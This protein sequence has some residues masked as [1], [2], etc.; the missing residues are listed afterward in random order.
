MTSR[1]RALAALLAV[2]LLGP[3]TSSASGFLYGENGARSL[4]LG[5]AFAGQADDLTAIQH[6]PAGL[7]QQQ[8]FSFLVDLFLL[9][10]EVTFQRKDADGT[11][12]A[13]PVSNSGG[14]FLLPFFAAGYG[15]PVANRRLTLSI[16]A[17][18]PP[19]VGRYAFPKPNYEKV[20]KNGRLTYV[21]D[22]RKFAPQRYGLIEND[23]IVLFPSLSA[24]YEV[25]P[26][27]SVGV[28]LQYVYSHID[29]QIAATSILFTPTKQLHEDADFDS[30]LV[31][32]QTGKPTATG[33]LGVLVKP[34]DF[35]R[36]GISYRPPVPIDAEGEANIVL[37]PIPK[38]FYSVEGNRATFEM[39]L[40]QELKIGA[41][42]TPIK[43]L[44]VNVDAVYQGWQSVG[45][46]L[47]T[48]LDIR[49]VS[50]DPAV[51][52]IHL[53]PIHIP[54]KWRHIWSFR[55]GAQYEF[56][57][58][59]T[60]RAGVLWEQSAAGDE[61]LAIDFMH[62]TRTFITG[63]L[64]YKIPRIGVS[65]LATGAYQPAVTKEVTGSEVRAPNTDHDI[66]GSIIGNGTLTGGGWIL[67][68]GIR[69]TFGGG[70][71]AASGTRAVSPNEGVLTL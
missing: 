36:I 17:Y 26:K 37:G 48:P 40:P 71:P 54:K 62:P 15:L 30:V 38:Q 50:P 8:G 24:A 53:E 42:L 27:L 41:H 67:G 13:G 20:E 29:F 70:G 65:V 43:G 21:E 23:I 28:S 45:E 18:G 32:D 3:A 52:P 9:N 22:P 33:V 44:G 10:H 51:E 5:G 68:G 16:G 64:E 19:S 61:R 7:A 2:G 12:V 1:R 47:L 39:T 46:F 14:K 66:Q 55:G 57:F 63:G 60:A 31:L 25:H 56:P 34:T 35:L 49:L 4:Q 69:G 58:G 59:L 11:T 6:N